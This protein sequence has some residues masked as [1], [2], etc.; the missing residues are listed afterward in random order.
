MSQ[1]ELIKIVLDETGMEFSRPLGSVIDESVLAK[2][3]ALE[4]LEGHEHAMYCSIIVS[5]RSIA[6][7][8]WLN[9]LVIVSMLASCL[10]EPEQWHI[11]SAKR[12][13]R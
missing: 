2:D 9:V 5:L 7:H 3:P 11:G 13:L 6:T 10:H 4:L 8:T 1:K 12:A